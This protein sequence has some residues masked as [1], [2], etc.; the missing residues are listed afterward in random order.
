M[1]F[2]ALD[3]SIDAFNRGVAAKALH[4]DLR[5]HVKELMGDALRPA[6]AAHRGTYEAEAG[7]ISAEIIRARFFDIKHA[8]PV[9]VHSGDGVRFT[10]FMVHWPS[11]AFFAS[12]ISCLVFSNQVPLLPS[13]QKQR[14]LP[15][16]FAKTWPPRSRQSRTPPPRLAFRCA[17][18]AWSKPR[19]Q[20]Q[21]KQQQHAVLSIW[22]PL[23]FPACHHPNQFQQRL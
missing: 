20:Q 19:P 6:T 23:L 9:H 13:S 1:L 15:R 4:L 3:N 16:H 10:R 5:A 12:K 17:C 18:S 22:P 14:S 8:D 21:P 2:G 7:N 11:M